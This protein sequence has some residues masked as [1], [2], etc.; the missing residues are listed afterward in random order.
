MRQGVLGHGEHLQDVGPEQG[1][2]V[3]QINLLEVLTHE[4]LERI[5]DQDIDPAESRQLLR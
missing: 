4:L 1:L 2:H 5:V 3:V